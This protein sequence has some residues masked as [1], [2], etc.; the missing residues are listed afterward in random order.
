MEETSKPKRQCSDLSSLDLHPLDWNE[1]LVG[2]SMPDTL[3]I[4]EKGFS[5]AQAFVV[6]MTPDDEA[7]LREHLLADDDPVDEKE[8][9][10]QVRPN[11]LFEAG[12]AVGR[13]RVPQLMTLFVDIDNDSVLVD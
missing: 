12:M 11:V 5:K 13:C 4:I 1:L 6:L 10:P 3:D 7:R 8:L 2:V 9:T